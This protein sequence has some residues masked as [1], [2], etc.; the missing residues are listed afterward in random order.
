[1]L[2]LKICT[3]LLDT[4]QVLNQEL[5]RELAQAQAQAAI[6][7]HDAE[8][9][10]SQQAT[11][12]HQMD[13]LQREQVAV[14]QEKAHLETALA[15]AQDT[16]AAL[17]Q[18]QTTLGELY[19]AIVGEPPGADANVLEEVRFWLEREGDRATHLEHTIL[20]LHQDKTALEATLV[21][22]QTHLDHTR[23]TN[24]SL[25]SEINAFQWQIQALQEQNAQLQSDRTALEAH[26]QGMEAE[27]RQRTEAI[28]H[29]QPPVSS[30]AAIT[31]Q[32]K[33]SRPRPRPSG[34]SKGHSGPAKRDSFQQIR[35]IGP[36]YEK[37]LYNAGIITF[38]DLAAQ[39]PE[40]IRE[41]IQST[42]HKIGP[43]AW[44]EEA[45]HQ[46]A[47]NSAE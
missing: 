7:R 41:I 3:G 16:M 5:Q 11:L 26:V 28:A 37:R 44:I 39:N 25:E 2:R 21:D 18:E 12:Q 8:Q 42:S 38:A 23:M 6:A 47:S 33:L 27:R 19:E 15:S 14:E 40:R 46:I 20:D 45:R 9:A 36:V 13:A 24:A 30:D 22:L 1:M 4:A 10:R 31:P 29:L 43:E 32:P 35:G 34:P 17:T